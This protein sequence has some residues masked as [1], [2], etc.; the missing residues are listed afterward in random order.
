MNNHPRFSCK[1]A[2]KHRNP[3]ERHHC[4]LCAAKHPTFLCP[5]A[6]VN[7]GPGQPNW[8]KA[9]YKRAKQEGREADYRW[10]P[11][12]TQVEVDDPAS[13]SQYQSEA[14]QPLCAAAAMMHGMPMAPASSAHGGCPPIAEHQEFTPCMPPPGM[15]MMQHE[16]IVPN[17]GYKIPSNLWDLNIAQC[18]HAPSPLATFIRHCNTMES[19]SYPTH[20]KKG[21]SA[22]VDGI[23]DRPQSQH[24]L[25]GESRELQKYSEK[26][27]YESTCC[28]L[29]AEGIQTEI[30]DE[31][32]KVH[33]WIAG[34]TEDLLR[35]KRLQHAQPAW[36]QQMRNPY[37]SVQPAPPSVPSQPASS[38]SAS[39]VPVKPA[40]MNRNPSMAAVPDPW[41]DA[42]MKQ[43]RQ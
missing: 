15:D 22:P 2:S 1:H 23:S 40:P 21:T 34:R 27:A 3:L 41:A 11:M 17:P 14:P 33:H 43:Q 30:A 9:E 39:M 16:V 13:T 4:T 6:Q 20:S 26:L 10:G 12:V 36:A 19:P 8:Y 18:V 24:I 35:M 31:Q 38:S 29:W 28:R 32:E 5:R 42:K 25:H 37:Q 7:G